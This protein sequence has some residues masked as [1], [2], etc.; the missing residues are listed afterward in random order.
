MKRRTYRLWRM[1]SIL[2]VM[3]VAFGPMVKIPASAIAQTAGPEADYKG[4]R[5]NG[6]SLPVVSSE[7]AYAKLNPYLQEL[8]LGAVTPPGQTPRAPQQPVGVEFY[9]EV[10]DEAT[11]LKIQ[12]YFVDNKLYGW[13]PELLEEGM[14][15]V[16]FGLIMP[17][18]LMKVAYFPEVSAI[19]G[20]PPEKAIYE[21]VPADDTKPEATPKD[22]E[23]LRANAENLRAGSLPWE[24]AK[25]IGDSGIEQSPSVPEDWF[26]TWD[27]TGPVQASEAWARGFEG[28]GVKVAVIDDGIDF[29][30]PDLIGKQ[31][32]YTTTVPAYTYLN[33]YAYVM[34]AFTLRALFYQYVYGYTYIS[35]GFE[36]VTLM[37]TSA[38]PAV[39]PCGAG[40]KCFSYTPLIEYGEAGSLHTYIFP[41]AWSKSGVVH[42]GTHHDGS[43]RDYVWGE[44]VTILVTDPNTA[45]VYDTV[46][47]D[48]DNDYNF[49][50]EKP[51]TKADPDN[52]ATRN[53][54][55]SY[56]DM[57]G[58][59]KADLSGGALYFIADGVHWPGGFDLFAPSSF[60]LSAPAKGSMVGLHGPWISGYS[61]G[62]QCASAVAASGQTTAMVPDFSNLGPGLPPGSTYGAAPKVGLVAMNTAYN[63]TGGI[64]YRDAY[65][66]AARGWDGYYASNSLDTDAIQITSNSYGFSNDFNKGW[67]EL[68]FVV[69][70]IMRRR[71]PS[72]Q[73]LFSSG[74][75]GPAYGNVPPPK[76]ATLGISVGASS[77]YGSTGWDTITSTLQINVNDMVPFSN[78][79]PSGRQGAGVDILAGGAYAAGS[80]EL[81]YFSS[82]LWGVLDG[83]RSWDSWGGTSRS[84]PAAAGV[85]ALIYQAYKANHGVFPTSDVAK[86]IFMSSATDIK[87]DVFRMGAGVVNA[88]KGTLMASGEFGPSMAPDSFNWSPGD[89]R[90]TTYPSYA[91]VVYPGDI[92]TKTFTIN[93]PSAISTTVDISASYLQLVD[94][95]EFGYDVT[96]AMIAAESVYGATNQDNFYKA[97]NF[98][99]PLYGFGGDDKLASI[100]ADTE[101][102]VVRQILPYG[103]FDIGSDYTA[104]NRFYLT[105]YNWTDVNG[106]GKVWTDKDSNGVVNFINDPSTLGQQADGAVE[107]AWGDPRTELDR[108][109]Y[110]RFGY[111]RPT[112]NTYQLDVQMPL[113]RMGDGIFIGARHLYSP[114]GAAITSHL[115]YRVE[116]YK[117]VPTPFMSPSVSNLE[118]PAGGSAT[119]DG[120][121][122]VPGDMPPG[123]YAAQF[124]VSYPDNVAPDY[125]G[126]TILIPVAINVATRF[127]GVQQLGGA[128]SSQYDALSPYNNGLVR[129]FFDWSWREESGD[130]RQFFMDIDPDYFANFDPN[131][132]VILKDEWQAPAPHTDIDTVVLGPVTHPLADGYTFGAYSSGTTPYVPATYGQNGL[133]IKGQSTVDVANRSTWHFNTTSGASEDWL[134][135]P[136]ADGLHEIMQHN[137]LYEADQFG[138]V[139]T[140]T[141]GMLSEDVHYFSIDTYQDHG[142]LGRMVLTSTIPLNGITTSGYLLADDVQTWSNEPLN[143][144]GEGTLEWSYPLTVTD[145]A[146]LAVSTTSSSVADL[147]LYLFFWNGSAW[148]QKASSAGGTSAEHIEI[149]NPANGSWLIAIDNFSGPAGAFNMTRL[150]KVKTPGLQIT[151]EPTGAVAANQPVTVTL[152]YSAS[153]ALGENLGS[154]IVGIPEAP[155]LKNVPITIN[156]LAEP[157][158]GIE[159]TVDFSTHFAGDL[160]Q[161]QIDLFNVGVTDTIRME[162]VI[163]LMTS[164]DSS[165][166]VCFPASPCGLLS[167]D[168]LNDKIIYEGVLSPSDV[169]TSTEDFE[170][171]GAWPVGWT[172]RH[173]GATSGEWV[174]GD[175]DPHSGT[176][177]ASVR[178]DSVYASDEWLFTPEF[179]VSAVDKQAS[180]WVKT[181]TV[182][183]GAT[184]TLYAT[185]TGE[186]FTDE[187]WDVIADEDWPT[188]AWRLVTIDLSSYVG[189]TIKLGWRY[190]GLDGNSVRLDDIYIPMLEALPAA[191]ITLNV[192][193][194][195]GVNGGD[196]IT[197]TASVI[198]VHVLPQ[199]TQYSAPVITEAIFHIGQENL[200][201]STKTAEEFVYSSDQIHY[202]I[203][204]VNSG[205]AAALLSLV[206]PIPAGTVYFSHDPGA[207]YLFQFDAGANSMKWDGILLPGETRTFSFVVTVT[208]A[209]FTTVTN[210][211]VLNWGAESMHLIANTV[212]MGK[213]FLPFTLVTAP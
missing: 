8:A 184:L 45:G 41:G 190:H 62:T 36:G 197:N 60:G 71:A 99:I 120:V 206:D 9:G 66:M 89:F 178:Y 39:F 65:Y 28:Q 141:L 108:W 69:E 6:P 208:S 191:T 87:N 210:D 138:V 158:R 21:P 165:N 161:Y 211:A 5:P 127:T 200:S 207:G 167:Y 115:K 2:M 90:G 18:N 79:G 10:Q 117:R 155:Y 107:L 183:P 134:T 144:T 112:G 70:D 122:N 93:N 86:A 135:F 129:G 1:F 172:T 113:Q 16:F 164:Y 27:P 195:A 22:W 84:S 48:L 77:E 204:L 140:K 163:P 131:A 193:V 31:E 42:V 142:Y 119:F 15:N 61:H 30:H 64:T 168:G 202:T 72:L 147:D 162:D 143:F 68:S 63:F 149:S 58:D 7:E 26:E 12:S 95:V 203:T 57:T 185:D 199:E 35:A 110:A 181:D 24:Q 38:T 126:K 166:V 121:L 132:L 34:D 46:Y 11:F 102:M 205:D 19:V 106:N 196:I 156:K 159:K 37:D 53:N 4:A 85:L 175:W 201:T 51:V 98:F 148:V 83:N 182:Y 118:V 176:Y 49:S 100:P 78:A 125:D 150:L 56:R 32:I 82:D 14:V 25:V 212:I 128:F 194:D 153:L 43:L 104:D 174:V 50:D 47:V 105:V 180:F 188:F 114:A 145:A 94:S 92:W 192:L 91:H 189:E 154:L 73:F 23:K 67:D 169:V 33:G 55:I 111:N 59:G 139:F 170:H 160:V 44:R 52:P 88:D 136:M 171:G 81:N 179:T 75:G 198:G 177:H 213:L 123:D 124:E 40:Y 173:D 74:N 17:A 76:P 96:P 186:T 54:V 133:A 13:N 116:F 187:L 209:A 157:G 130:W 151:V 137:V 29:A 80:E 103:E 20:G 152:N 109:E 3:M 97:F 101:L 146:L